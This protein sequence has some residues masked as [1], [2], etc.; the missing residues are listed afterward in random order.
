M[1]GE[2]KETKETTR[3]LNEIGLMGVENITGRDGGD[4]RWW[5][6]AILKPWR[7]VCEMNHFPKTVP[8]TGG[9]RNTRMEMS[10]NPGFGNFN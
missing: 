4:M 8:Q 1:R 7:E 6:T 10:S 5:C 9:T 2:G 3:G